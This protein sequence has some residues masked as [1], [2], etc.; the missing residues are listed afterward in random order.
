M[1]MELS[2][3]DLM[4][5]V[6]SLDRNIERTSGVLAGWPLTT[7]YAKQE[8]KQFQEEI[9]EMRELRMRLYCLYEEM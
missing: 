8:R 6:G 1:L 7:E 5:L 4:Y 2:K 3:H 9:E